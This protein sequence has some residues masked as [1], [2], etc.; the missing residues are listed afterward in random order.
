MEKLIDFECYPVRKAL[1][2]LLQ[3]KSTKRNIIWA[4]DPPSLVGMEYSDRSQIMIHQI[5]S[6]PNAIQPRI[7]EWILDYHVN[8][9]VKPKGVLLVNAFRE[10]PI[11]ERTEPVFPKQMLDYSISR[12]HCLISTTQF[13]CMFINCR[14]NKKSKEII[15][16][17]IKTTGVYNKYDEK[18]ILGIG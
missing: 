13:L 11:V 1:K 5:E 8:T 2:V 9:G 10:K 7:E 16:E 14:N 15:M 6:A 3:D 4:T 18:V 17:F 12:E